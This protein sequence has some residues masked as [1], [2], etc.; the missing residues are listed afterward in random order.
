MSRDVLIAYLLSFYMQGLHINIVPHRPFWHLSTVSKC[1]M[2]YYL[3]YMILDRCYVVLN[4]RVEKFLLSALCTTKI[5]YEFTVIFNLCFFWMLLKYR[6]FAMPLGW[7]H[8][9][10]NLSG[11]FFLVIFVALTY[12]YR[13][14]SRLGHGCLQS[15]ICAQFDWPTSCVQLIGTDGLSFK[16][17]QWFLEKLKVYYT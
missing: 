11:H 16:N 10:K 8:T 9:V 6:V 3:H 14:K 15:S 17:I 1:F 2:F 5:H 12:Q 13:N 4:I 7:Y